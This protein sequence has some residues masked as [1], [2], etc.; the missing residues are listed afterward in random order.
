[1]ASHPIRWGITAC[2]LAEAEA[3]AAAEGARAERGQAA[4]AASVQA[5]RGQFRAYQQGKAEEVAGLEAR[6]R[7][8][9]GIDGRTLRRYSAELA[10]PVQPRYP[11]RG[12]FVF[13]CKQ[14]VISPQCK[15]GHVRKWPERQAFEACGSLSALCWKL[16]HDALCCAGSHGSPAWPLARRIF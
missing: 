14:A 15:C 2:R 4:A 3:E 12:S 7:R 5:L 6:L 16:P 11:E 1:M 8:L 13:C 10:I 9:L